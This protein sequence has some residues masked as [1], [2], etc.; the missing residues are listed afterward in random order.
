MPAEGLD[1]RT[2]S[3]E[4]ESGVMRIED[5]SIVKEYALKVPRKSAIEGLEF[6]DTSDTDNPIL[7]MS[8][9]NYGGSLNVLE[10]N[11]NGEEWNL[12]ST[13]KVD[14]QYFGMG[15]TTVNSDTY[16]LTWRAQKVLKYSSTDLM[17]DNASD[18]KVD[19]KELPYPMK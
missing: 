11:E 19:L 7:L 4:R 5:A 17:S 3:V 2:E 18:S 10:M 13:I 16:V 14:P 6:M 9:G 1:C 12:K 15:L 8:T